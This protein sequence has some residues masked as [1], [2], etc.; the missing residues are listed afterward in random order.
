ML[1]IGTDPK[2]QILVKRIQEQP[3]IRVCDRRLS[4][5]SCLA[6]IGHSMYGYRVFGVPDELYAV[7]HHE[8]ID[9]VMV[10]MPIFTLHRFKSCL[11]VCEQ[12][13]INC[14]IVL[15][16]DSNSNFKLFIDDILDLPLISFSYR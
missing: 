1:I 5:G 16:T 13:G 2:V 7:L 9:E 11:T 3:E 14:R 8:V 4:L 10:A 15:D 12:M 6:E